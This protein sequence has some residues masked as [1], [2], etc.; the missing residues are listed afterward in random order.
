MK[1]QFVI[2][3]L[4]VLLVSVVLSGCSTQNNNENKVNNTTN[5]ENS[6]QNNNET[7]INNT[8]NP[9]KKKTSL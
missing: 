7:L 6:T 8:I 4:V 9:E 2:I 3:G 5:P 1:K